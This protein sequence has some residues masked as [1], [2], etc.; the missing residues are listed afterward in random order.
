MEYP[1]PGF[2]RDIGMGSGSEDMVK[3]VWYIKDHR[4]QAERRIGS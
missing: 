1:V 3:G 4:G 2:N